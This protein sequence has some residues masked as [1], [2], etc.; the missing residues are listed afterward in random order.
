MLERRHSGPIRLD[1]LILCFLS[2]CLSGQLNALRH[3]NSSEA[4]S[5]TC[6]AGKH[7]VPYTQLMRLTPGVEQVIMVYCLINM[8]RKPKE[9]MKTVWK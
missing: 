1:V 2:F 3:T 4:L 5:A 9:N 6:Q 8:C 7:S